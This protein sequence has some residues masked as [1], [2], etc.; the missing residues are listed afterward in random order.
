M[1]SSSSIAYIGGKIPAKGCCNKGL[2]L[3]TGYGYGKEEMNELAELG[4][5]GLGHWL[6]MM[7]KRRS[8]TH[9]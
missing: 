8:S 1:M 6:I 4:S 7:Q 2:G 9:A 3:H 5:L